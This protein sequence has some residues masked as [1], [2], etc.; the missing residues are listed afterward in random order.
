M[1]SRMPECKSDRMPENMSSWTLVPPPYTPPTQP[2]S[3]S[4]LREGNFSLL[5]AMICMMFLVKIILNLWLPHLNKKVNWWLRPKCL[6]YFKDA[7]IK[8]CLHIEGSSQK[9]SHF[10]I[11]CVVGWFKFECPNMTRH[12]PGFP[13]TWHP[14]HS[15][16]LQDLLDLVDLLGF[17]PFE[18]Y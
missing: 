10:T 17:H 14:K 11:F 3:A 13:E 8:A 16:S 9:V 15:V 12:W 5:R 2:F 6:E 1:S 7:P 4:L 18:A